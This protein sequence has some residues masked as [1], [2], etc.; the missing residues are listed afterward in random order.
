MN[1]SGVAARDEEAVA[2]ATEREAVPRLLERQELRLLPAGE[3][4][5]AHAVLIVAAMHGDHPFVVGRD[6]QFERQIADQRLLARR[7]DAPAIEEEI[8][9]RLQPRALADGGTVDFFARLADRPVLS[10]GF[11]ACGGGGEG[12]K[13]DWK[14]ARKNGGCFHN[15]IVFRPPRK[16]KGKRAVPTS[17][18]VSSETKF[19]VESK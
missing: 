6:D 18:R 19:F 16:I 17:R 3:V 1:F 11:L 10:H 13:E 12:G 4:K 14:Y 7:R 5:E 8:R 15:I 9:V 2:V